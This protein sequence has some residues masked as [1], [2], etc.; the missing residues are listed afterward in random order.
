MKTLKFL[1]EISL[2]VL[3]CIFYLI[4]VCFGISFLLEIIDKK[5]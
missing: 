5:S 3:E 1:G 4:G 2:L